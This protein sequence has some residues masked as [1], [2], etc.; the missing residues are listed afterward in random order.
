MM[1]PRILILSLA[2]SLALITIPLSN[3]EGPLS[4]LTLSEPTD[5][6]AR[7]GNGMIYLSWGPPAL[8]PSTVQG[9]ILFR[10]DPQGPYSEIA[11]THGDVLGFTDEVENGLEYTYKVRAY[12]LLEE[13][14]DSMTVKA[15]GDGIRPKVLSIDPEHGAHLKDGPL[16][17]SWDAEDEGSGIDTYALEVGGSRVYEG[18]DPLTVI[19]PGEGI[20]I[21]TAIAL[22]RAGNEG[23]LTA[24]ITIDGTAPRV[25]IDRPTEGTSISLSYIPLEWSLDEVNPS[26][27]RVMVD[28]LSMGETVPDQY[29]DIGPLIPGPHTL[30]LSAE[31]QAGNEGS[32]MVNFT[33]DLE[34]PI[35]SLRREIPEITNNSELELDLR[36]DDDFDLEPNIRIS[37]N[38]LVIDPPW[39]GTG[40][41][42]LL[43]EGSNIISIAG[44]DLAGNEATERYD[45]VLDTKI[46][47]I[48]IDGIPQR[49]V[50]S[51][52]VRWSID[53]E[54]S[55]LDRAYLVV[56]GKGRGR[57]DQSGSFS[58]EGL[59]DGT[60]TLLFMA[61][62]KA[63]NIASEPILFDID[64]SIPAFISATPSEGIS[65]RWT[66]IAFEFTETIDPVFSSIHSDNATG[67]LEWRGGTAIFMPTSPLELGSLIDLLIVVQDL[68]GHRLCPFTITVTTITEGNIIGLVK[69]PSGDPIPNVR[70]ILDNGR[71]TQTDSEG[72]F[73]L[74]TPAGERIVFIRGP[75]RRTKERTVRLDAGETFDLGVVQMDDGPSEPFLSWWDLALYGGSGL[76]LIALMGSIVYLVILLRRDRYED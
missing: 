40:P 22:D 33:V 32:A 20:F 7:P 34:P 67:T 12:N 37:L 31:D 18:A 57:I 62:D 73:N 25:R 30:I 76:V 38:G 65:D 53:D 28:G 46:P 52:V 2:A 75:E 17:V 27:A 54:G 5:L 9:Y 3:A 6:T 36:V 45:V 56:D 58:P 49:P 23:R 59:P 11:R 44:T 19:D 39:P 50:E 35:I 1:G 70:I 26:I 21:I 74:T 69:S 66:E 43:R 16:T 15:A 68:A 10:A 55:G 13:G 71:A 63:G 8:G 47:E 14:P 24:E 48:A 29:T 61:Y 4:R 64:T 42:L 60:H 41:S 72:R 51:F